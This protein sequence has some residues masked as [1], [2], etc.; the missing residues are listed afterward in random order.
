MSTVI[1]ISAAAF[2]APGAPFAV[3]TQLVTSAPAARTLSPITY[4]QLLFDAFVWYVSLTI[5][6]HFCRTATEQQQHTE[7]RSTGTC[8]LQC[9][10][11]TEAQVHAADNL[12]TFTRSCESVPSDELFEDEF[13]RVEFTKY[14]SP[15]R[16]ILEAPVRSPI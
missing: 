1:E 10:S 11:Y 13:S 7:R 12:L 8:A 9:F 5:T 2:C 6:Y 15:P 14:K 3:Q 16:I 4:V